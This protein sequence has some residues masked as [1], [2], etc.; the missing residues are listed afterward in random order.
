MNHQ[1]VNPFT[2]STGYV[3]EISYCLKIEVLLIT[4]AHIGWLMRL[5]AAQVLCT[6]VEEISAQ[7]FMSARV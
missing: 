1:R 3:A 7:V 6:L 4:V 5:R 2:I